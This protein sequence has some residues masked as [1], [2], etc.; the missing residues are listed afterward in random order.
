MERYIAATVVA[1]KRGIEGNAL[2]AERTERERAK[3]V[4]FRKVLT[5]ECTIPG[6]FQRWRVN[7]G[8]YVGVP[9]SK[10]VYYSSS[11]SVATVPYSSIT[12][13]AP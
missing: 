12:R 8:S 7:S 13:L 10:C 5:K 9:Y 3:I 1:E 4:R 6:V 2:C 11:K